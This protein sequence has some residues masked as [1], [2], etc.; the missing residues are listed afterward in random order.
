MQT[1]NTTLIQSNTTS[2]LVQTELS[3]ITK[4]SNSKQLTKTNKHIHN[5]KTIHKHPKLT[6]QT[7]RNITT[8]SQ[9]QPTNN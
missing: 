3:N 8:R 9:I 7:P 1:R 2:K 6:Q 5:H 4:A